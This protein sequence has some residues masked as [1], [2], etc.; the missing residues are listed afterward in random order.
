MNLAWQIAKALIV[1]TFGECEGEGWEE[2]TFMGGRPFNEEHDRVLEEDLMRDYPVS[3]S[4]WIV[5]RYIRKFLERTK[6][7]LPGRQEENL[8]NF[9]DSLTKAFWR[10]LREKYWKV[11]T[12]G[13]RV[14]DGR[15]VLVEDTKSYQEKEIKDFIQE[16]VMEKFGVR[17]QIL[18]LGVE[19]Q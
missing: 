4:F 12:I 16:V 1:E 19:P 3:C 10:P 8:N 2:E 5:Q 11:D 7:E 14:K 18:A 13:V 6:G 15:L 9:Q 17:L